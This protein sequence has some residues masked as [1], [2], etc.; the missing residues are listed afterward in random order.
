MSFI[1]FETTTQTSIPKWRRTKGGH[2]RARGSIGTIG[3]NMVTVLSHFQGQMDDDG[4]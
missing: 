1:K 2:Y 3:I 4:W